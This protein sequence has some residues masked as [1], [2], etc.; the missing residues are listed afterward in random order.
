MS[1]R[2]AVISRPG[3]GT[4][5]TPVGK[6]GTGPVS[7]VRGGDVDAS[8]PKDSPPVR[9]FRAPQESLGSLDTATVASLL[10]VAADVVLALDRGGTVRD[11][12][13]GSD[14]LAAEWQAGWLG[15]PW[16]ETVTVESRP[17]VETLLRE[18]GAGGPPPGRAVD[19]PLPRGP[20]PPILY[21]ALA[22]R[23]P[24]P[25]GAGGPRPPGA[26]AP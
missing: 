6:A 8:R 15:R 21:A 1:R 12:A 14:E 10:T 24:G 17:K 18:A 25:G 13:F 3:G 23:P 26:A 19:H 5:R 2:D 16:I 11:A 9:L 7:S 20:D 4:G 22:P